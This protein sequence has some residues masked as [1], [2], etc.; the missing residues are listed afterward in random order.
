[1]GG[2][3]FVPR[4]PNAGKTAGF[5]RGLKVLISQPHPSIGER[6][7]NIRTA[8][9]QGYRIKRKVFV[10]LFAGDGCPKKIFAGAVVFFWQRGHEWAN[11]SLYKLTV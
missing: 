9:F 1:M 11:K 10:R 7:C 3:F 2:G 8:V 4:I 5:L 6:G